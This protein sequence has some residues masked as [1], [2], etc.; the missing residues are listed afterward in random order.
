[1]NAPSNPHRRPLRVLWLIKGLGPGGAERLL[2]SQAVVRDR[3]AFDC[4]AA[5]LLPWKDHFVARLEAAEVPVRCLGVRRELDLRW[6]RRL[7]RLL[8]DGHYDVVHVHSPY[9]AGVARVVV[10]SLP[11]HLRPAV[12][13]TEHNIW[14]GY[15]PSTRLLTAATFGWG[16]AWLAVS[17]AVRASLPDRLRDRFEVVVNGVLIDELV[18]HRGS[19]QQARDEL[20]LRPDE[21]AIATVANLHRQKGYPDLMLAARALVDRGYPVRFIAIGQGPLEAELH[22]LH[23]SL[24][25]GDRFAFLGYRSDVPR[26]LSGCDM[27]VLASLYEGYPIAVMEALVMGLPVV[28]TSVGGN[29]EAIRHG[30]EGLLVPPAS[31]D[32]LAAALQELVLEPE[33]RRRMSSAAMERGNHFD[34]RRAVRRIE[35]IYRLQT[36]LSNCRAGP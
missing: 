4:Q 27:F 11:R 9:A 18:A 19:R 1:V 29:L 30:I 3:E 34:M 7:R 21:V 25:L 6:S 35:A 32:R 10:R 28:A 31:P 8:R 22:E 5:Y 36:P 20:G 13:S 23:G 2:V 17:E 12:V 24:G 15:R 26:L 16:D 14:Q 33:L